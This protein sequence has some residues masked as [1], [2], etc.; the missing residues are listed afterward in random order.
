MKTRGRMY[1]PEVPDNQ[2]D[3]MK[4]WALID[5][6]AQ[7]SIIIRNIVNEGNT[8]LTIQLIAKCCV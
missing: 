5:T 1:H 7:V 6:G 4:V 3:H 2:E 8:N